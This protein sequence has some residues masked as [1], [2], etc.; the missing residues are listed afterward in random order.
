MSQ[1]QSKVIHCCSS[2]SQWQCVVL[3]HSWLLSSTE[4]SSVPR[5]KVDLKQKNG[6]RLGEHRIH[7]DF[8][9]K[10]KA[11]WQVPDSGRKWWAMCWGGVILRH[12]L[13]EV[14]K[15]ASGTW[16][17]C[18]Q[19]EAS[20]LRCD[21]YKQWRGGEVMCQPEKHITHGVRGQLRKVSFKTHKGTSRTHQSMCVKIQ[22][23]TVKTYKLPKTESQG[24]EAKFGE[25]IWGEMK[26][27]LEWGWEIRE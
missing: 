16:E 21:L 26:Q 9:A 5:K 8:T 14:Q 19:R 12:C 10:E 18:E 3:G 24:I 15:E 27:N 2:S 17:D 11:S 20:W 7:Q 4:T 22:K 6:F 1:E 23:K 13:Q 25:K